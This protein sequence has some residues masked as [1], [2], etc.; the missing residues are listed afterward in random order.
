MVTHQ[1]HARCRPVK[2]RRSETDVLPLSHP[3]NSDGTMRQTEVEAFRAASSSARLTDENKE[4][5]E[6]DFLLECHCLQ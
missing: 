1:L 5:E 3:T 4:E 6:E 2:V